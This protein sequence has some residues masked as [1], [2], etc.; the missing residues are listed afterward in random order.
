VLNKKIKNELEPGT[1][2]SKIA[3]YRLQ[4]AGLFLS[5]LRFPLFALRPFNNTVHNN[6]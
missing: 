2:I 5:G 1:E 4:G 6:H 3:R